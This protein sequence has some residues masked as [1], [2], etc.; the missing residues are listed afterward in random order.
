MKYANILCSHCA[1]TST[2]FFLCADGAANSRYAISCKLKS[3]KN[4]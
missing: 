1:A 2:L 3:Q 4:S